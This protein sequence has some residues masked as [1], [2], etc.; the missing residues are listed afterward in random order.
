MDVFVASL[1]HHQLLIDLEQSLQSCR[2]LMS[3]IDDHI[4][5]LA[6]HNDNNPSPSSTSF[7][8]KVRAMLWDRRMQASVN[9]LHNQSSALT[10]LLTALN[11]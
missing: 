1:Q 11:W 2:I 9:H 5:T 3:F 7:E 6:M 8:K 4:S 10:L